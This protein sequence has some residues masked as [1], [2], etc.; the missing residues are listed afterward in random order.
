MTQELHQPQEG[1]DVGTTAA[2]RVRMDP[3][4]KAKWVAAL[5]SGQYPQ[6]RDHLRTFEDQYC[7]L[8]VLTDLMFPN[9]WAV[10]DSTRAYEHAGRYCW[11]AYLEDNPLSYRTMKTLAGMNDRS[12]SFSEIADW[13]EAN[14]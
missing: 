6:G 5:R 2:A 9:E 7:C 4:L 8:G 13:I 14:L 10:S 3:E 1:S 11:P 12:K